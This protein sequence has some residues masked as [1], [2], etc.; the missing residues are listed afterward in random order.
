V[1]AWRL[2]LGILLAIGALG[3]LG[4]I[5]AL[6]ADATGGGASD[7]RPLVGLL[8]VLALVVLAGIDFLASLIGRRHYKSR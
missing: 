2:T 5:P 3:L 8:L 4:V 7:A 6:A 1:W